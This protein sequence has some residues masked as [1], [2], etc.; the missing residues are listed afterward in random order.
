MSHPLAQFHGFLYVGGGLKEKFL[1]KNFLHASM[2]EQID[3]EISNRLSGFR[4]LAWSSSNAFVQ[5]CS[6]W[7]RFESV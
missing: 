2:L 4:F 7:S 1:T 5:F 6:F 3:Q